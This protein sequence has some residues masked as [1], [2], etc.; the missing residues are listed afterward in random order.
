MPK[1]KAQAKH[2]LVRMLDQEEHSSITGES[3]NSYNHF[4]NQFCGF[5]EN[6][7]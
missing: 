2:M 1:T 7:E 4:E 6:W 5:S 3:V